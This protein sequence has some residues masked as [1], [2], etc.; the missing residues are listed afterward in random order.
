MEVMPSKSGVLK[1]LKKM[2]HRP[3]YSPEMSSSSSPKSVFQITRKPQIIHKG[4]VIR[5]IPTPVTPTSKKRRAKDMAKNIT[6]KKK[7]VI[8]EDED[9]VVLDSPIHDTIVSSPKRDSL[10]HQVI[11]RKHLLLRRLLSYHPECRIPN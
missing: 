5:E 9:E 7:G 11:H 1:F 2:A 4:V 10:I 6:K 3:R 8:V